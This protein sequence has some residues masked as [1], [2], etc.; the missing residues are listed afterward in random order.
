[1]RN[2]MLDLVKE[3]AETDKQIVLLVTH[4]QMMRCGFVIRPSSSQTTA[5]A[6]W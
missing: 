6:G 3:I 5:L 4:S 1:M 2:E